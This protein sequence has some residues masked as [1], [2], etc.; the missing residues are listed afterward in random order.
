MARPKKPSSKLAQPN[1]FLEAINFLS[2]ITKDVGAPFETHIALYNKTALAGNGVT[3]AGISIEEDLIAAPHNK[4]LQTA[5]G[6]CGEGYS[7]TQLDASKLVLKAGKFKAIIPCLDINLLTQIYPDEPCAT[8]DDRLKEALSVIEIIKSE[9]AQ[10]VELLSFLLNG[11][12]LI[13]TDG[14]IILEYWHGIDLPTNIPIPKS[15][16]TPILQ[17]KKKLIR[18]GFSTSSVTFYFEDGSWVKSQ[19]Y[20][21]QWPRV[22]HIMDKACNAFP[23]P[24]DFFKAL[25]AVTPFSEEGNIYF[26]RE[27]LCSHLSVD[28]GATHEVQGLPKGPIYTA[29]YFHMIKNIAEKIDF[30]VPG[31]QGSYLCMFF[32]KNCRGVIAGHG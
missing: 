30:T 16:I 22:D 18:F 26:E 13:A 32:G 24:I 15:I 2:C 20:A 7:L 6:K 14:K 29:K 9:N 31:T 4:T 10:R 1:R 21:A 12:S 23:V 27:L 11:Q 5:L 3:A 19:L 8:I 28:K 25:D 17:N